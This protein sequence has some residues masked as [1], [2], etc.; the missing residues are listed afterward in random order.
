MMKQPKNN[1]GLVMNGYLKDQLPIFHEKKLVLKNKFERL[2][3][4]LTKLFDFV[5]KKKLLTDQ[6]ND[7]SLVKNG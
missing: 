4:V 6:V 2:S 3:S 5:L 7:V 1:V